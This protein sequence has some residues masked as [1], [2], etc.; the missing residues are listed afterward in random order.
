MSKNVYANKKKTNALLIPIILMMGFVPLIVHMFE[1]DANLSQFDWFPASSGLQTDFFFAWKM[2]AIVILG[3]VMI[4]IMLYR[5]LKKK[6]QFQFE[7][8]FYMLFVYAMFVAMSALFSSYKYWVVRGTYEL[9]EPVWAVFAYMILCYYVYNYV[10]EEKQVNKVLLWAGVGMAMVTLIGVFQ[11]FGK[12]FFKTGF[13]KHLITNTSFWG[14]LDSLNFNMAEGTSYTTLYNPNFLSFYFGMLIPLLACL[15]IG[16]KKVWQRAALVVAEILCIICLKGSGSDSGWMAV[17]AGAAIAVLVLL[18]RGKKL[19]YVGGAL[20]AAGIIGSIVIANTTSFGEKIKNTI[21][22]TYHME[23]QYSLND[24][25]TN[26]EDVVLKIWDNALSVSY[27]IAEDGTI[28]ILCKDSNGNPLGQTLA[29]EGTQTYSIDDERFANVQV[30]P[31]MFDQTAGISVYVDGI[32]WNF[33][34]TDDDGYE[35]LNPAG[36]L[37]KYEKVKQ[38]NLFKEDA[39]SF[40]G[41]IWNTTIPVLGKHVFVG[42]G[43]NTYLLERPQNDYFGQAYIYGFNTYDVKAHCWYLQQWVETGLFGTLALIGFLLWYIIRSVRIYRRVDLHEHLSWVG[44]GLFAA[45]LVYVIA[46]VVNDSNVCTAPVFW[47]M[48]GFGMAVNR[49]LVTKENLFVKAE[50]IQT[51]ENDNAD[52]QQKNDAAPVNE[53]V[54]AENKNGKQKASGKKQSRKHRKNQKK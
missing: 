7:N 13:G 29:D 30:Q 48:L 25:A 5:Y 50:D 44:F 27:D 42:S 15:F 51:T 24:I 9:F 26:D 6:E 8:S 36:K 19:R 3:V 40:R 14:N 33:V 38:S 54:N 32:S 34:K 41:H 49:M 18:S 10:Q 47:G 23:D 35:F 43:A 4:G 2:I 16:A 52:V 53:N 39:M 28:Q 17:A 46:A 22:G 31:V 21:T 20:V 12:D 11:Y 1:Y 37:V 45:V